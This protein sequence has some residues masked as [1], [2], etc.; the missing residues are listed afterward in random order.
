MDGFPHYVLPTVLSFLDI[1]R[2]HRC[3]CISKGW[4][5]F[6]KEHIRN[7][8]EEAGRKRTEVWKFEVHSS[9]GSQVDPCTNAAKSPVEENPKALGYRNQQNP[10]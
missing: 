4:E 5:L 1:R 10:M 2:I 9:F 8:R 6:V 3:A 7:I